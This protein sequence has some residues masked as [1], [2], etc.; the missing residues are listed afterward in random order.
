MNS[1][2]NLIDIYATSK[3][4][5]RVGKLHMNVVLENLSVGQ[6]FGAKA[7]YHLISTKDHGRLHE[8]GENVPSGIVYEVRSISG[9]QLEMRHTRC[10]R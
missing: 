10:R 4:S 1:G 8:F 6:P 3:L 7:E 2:W 5:Y 9:E